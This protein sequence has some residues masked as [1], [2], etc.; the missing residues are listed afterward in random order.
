MVSLLLYFTKKLLYANSV[1]PNQMPHFVAFELGL[2]CWYPK[3]ASIL[4]LVNGYVKSVNMSC[5]MRK[6]F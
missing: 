4:K 3:W 6:P 2:H 5:V 1:G